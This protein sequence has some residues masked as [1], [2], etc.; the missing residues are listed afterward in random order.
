MNVSDKVLPL[1][2]LGTNTKELHTRTSTPRKLKK[3]DGDKKKKLKLDRVFYENEAL[4]EANMVFWEL[5]K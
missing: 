2:N 1:E 5:L 4:R 3:N